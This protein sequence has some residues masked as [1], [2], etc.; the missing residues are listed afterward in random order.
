M[1]TEFGA[2]DSAIESCSLLYDFFGV[3]Y[4]GEYTV[5][6]FTQ[7]SGNAGFSIKPTDT[8]RAF[9]KLDYYQNLN[10]QGTFSDNASGFFYLPTDSI[11]KYNFS[12]SQTDSPSNKHG[13]NINIIRGE[14]YS[15]SVDVYVSTNH[16][17]TGVAPVLSLT[18]NLSGFFAT[19]T[20]T[21][22]FSKK[23]TWQKILHKIFVPS[24]QS[25]LGI[26]PNYFEVTVA[27]KTASH[28]YYTSGSSDGFV[29]GNTQGRVLNLY[30]GATYV[31]IQSN[32]GNINDEFYIST[33]PDA[34]GG[35]NAYTAGYSYFGN[36]GFDGYG[37]FTVP[38][39]APSILYY[40][41]KR[42]SS[43]FFGGKIYTIGGYNVGN[44]G[45][46]SN[47][48]NGGNGG[49][50]GN[51][52]NTSTSASEAYAVCFDP[53][54][55]ELTGSNLNGG[56]ILYKNMQ[57]EKNK[58][59][60]KGI[61]HPTKFTSTSRSSTSSIVD[62]TGK[63]NNSNMVNAMFDNSS[64]LYFGNRTNLNDGGVV[65]I[66]LKAATSKTFLIGS[67][68]TQTYDFWFTQTNNSYQKAYLFSRSGA[69]ESGYFIE[70]QGYPQLIF[71]QDGRVFFSFSSLVGKILSGYTQQ[72][73][74]LNTLYNV[75]IAV[76][77]SLASGLKVDV[78][79]NG[80]KMDV[81]IYTQLLPPISLKFQNIIPSS[82]NVG[83]SG[84]AGFSTNNT[85]F[86]CISSYNN[87]GESTP[88]QVLVAPIDPTRR[89]I[90]I[91]WSKVNNALGYYIYRSNSSV[92]GSY[93]LL[94]NVQ[95]NSTLSFDDENYQI[96]F[97]SPKTG[98]KF[99]LN[100]GENVTSLVDD[101]FAKVCFGNYPL[102]SLSLNHFEGYIYRIGIYS[103]KLSEYQ[104]KRN[105]N[106][107][108]Y[109]YSSQDPDV[110]ASLTRSRSVIY[111]RV[112]Q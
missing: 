11:Y 15:S 2:T 13:F 77:T 70:N 69:A 68:T 104:I 76:N 39:N 36:E 111:K 107:F 102:S 27:A 62:A 61:T 80:Q 103:A 110:I 33:T 59:M 88:S 84:N 48:G 87:I 66:N 64:H 7:P 57:F 31:F 9:Y 49:N 50:S 47:G 24:V 46:V 79:V 72:I 26:N 71:I 60:F 96:R 75:T 14:T 19:Q 93:S 105:Y 90:R 42:N 51:G 5:N 3:S 73:I 74:K 32:T 65:D 81:T 30:K 89:S 83:V 52:G 41:S 100:Y 29:I 108:L 10:G 86:Y 58:P 94:A 54:R 44:V 98:G 20:G 12:S 8:A 109:R 95:N 56:Y 106:S 17:R 38:F 101:K 1:K 82:G 37:V 53:T 91:S 22:D 6:L 40:N 45:N 67:A 4:P 21:Y 23:G 43:S 92:F 34:G 25:N 63:D 97:G 16:P 85:N 18:P 35:T 112:R 28:P 99:I 55:S 78:Y